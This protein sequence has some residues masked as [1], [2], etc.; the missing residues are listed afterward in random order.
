VDQNP[1]QVTLGGS[2]YPLYADGTT[3]S[4]VTSITLYNGQGAILL[5]SLPHG[6]AP[7]TVS[8]KGLT[9]TSRNSFEM[10]GFMSPTPIRSDPQVDIALAAALLAQDNR[11]NESPIAPRQVD[12]GSLAAK[13]VPAGDGDAQLPN[14]DVES[15][16]WTDGAGRSSYEFE[17]VWDTKLLVDGL[18][19]L[20]ADKPASPNL[21]G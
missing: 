7:L 20:T 17:F 21:D 15:A 14:S 11:P 13:P 8:G 16:S 19:L 9:S 2:Y 6:S 18:G 3:G 1:V 10:R 4:A 5:K 12:T